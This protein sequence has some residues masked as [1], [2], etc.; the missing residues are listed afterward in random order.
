M[1]V[2]HL[3]SSLDLLL[4]MAHFPGVSS[5]SGLEFDVSDLSE[6]SDDHVQLLDPHGCHQVVPVARTPSFA[7]QS[8]VQT[9]NL[10]GGGH[11]SEE[12]GVPL[13]GVGLGG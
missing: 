5:P 13:D 2:S 6:C 8:L 1:F 10:G 7:V 11:D 3:L 12:V 9:E 4:L